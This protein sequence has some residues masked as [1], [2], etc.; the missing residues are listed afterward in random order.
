MQDKI[1]EVDNLKIQFESFDRRT[2]KETKIVAVNGIRF[3][4]YKGET[5]GIVGESGS[6]KSV[7]A[8][9]LMRLLEEPPSELVS[10][11]ILFY[12]DGGSKPVDFAQLR[13]DEDMPPY[14][15]K[16]LAMIFQEPMTS[17]NPVYT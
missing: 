8:L 2:F 6:G 10:G 13:P 14:R 17:L 15:G 5:V 7:T 11:S 4:L 16:H 1:L 3:T 9:S 12:P